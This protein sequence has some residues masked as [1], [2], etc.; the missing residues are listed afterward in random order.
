MKISGSGKLSEGTINDELVVSGSA[1]IEG[2]F[3]CNGFRSSGSLRGDGNLIVHGDVRSSGSFRLKGSVQGDGKFRS[4]GSASIGGKILIKGELS[5][6]GSLRVDDRVEAVQGVR[7]SGS[8]HIQGELISQKTIDIEGS[9]SSGGDIKGEN[10]FFGTHLV[11]A[12]RIFKHPFKVNGSIFA[13]N[14]VDITGAN[15]AGDVKGREV[16]IGRGTEVLGTVY[17]VDT[18]EIHKQ[19]TVLNKP[20]QIALEELRFW[21]I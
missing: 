17:Y 9:I 20:I 6:S 7:S 2:N 13:T 12:K 1:K 21:I 3:E 4:S 14:R 10:V 18:I 16:R 5:S 8:I 19:A 11:R 15:V